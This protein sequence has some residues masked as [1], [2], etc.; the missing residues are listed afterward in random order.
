MV[1]RRVPISDCFPGGHTAEAAAGP[2]RQGESA[3][4]TE[5]KTAPPS[6][7]CRVLMVERL[8]RKRKTVGRYKEL[9]AWLSLIHPPPSPRSPPFGT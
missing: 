8:S 5:K 2:P 6:K 9:A 3:A 4:T 1:T 7:K